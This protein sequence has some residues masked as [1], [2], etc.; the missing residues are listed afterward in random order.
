MSYQ[1]FLK[2]FDKKLASYFEVQK[3]YICCRCWCSECCEQGDYPISQIE[4]EYLM[5]GF[6][7]LSLDMKRL[8][9]EN[10]KHFQSGGACPFLIDKKCSVYNYRPIICRVHGLAYLCRD[11]I[12]KV[13]YCVNTGKNFSSVYNDGQISIEPIKENLDTAPVLKNMPYGE[14]RNLADWLV[15]L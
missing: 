2:E 5:Q 7:E 6:A 13:P 10:F 9:Q 12:V 1:E 11:N 3:D 15:D 4:L 14:I 8:V